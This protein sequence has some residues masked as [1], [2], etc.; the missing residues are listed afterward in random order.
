MYILI[1]N[2][3]QANK[4]VIVLVLNNINISFEHYNCIKREVREFMAFGESKQEGV[5][6][7]TIQSRGLQ[8][9][10]CSEVLYSI[11]KHSYSR[12]LYAY[13][14]CAHIWSVLQLEYMM[15]TQFRRGGLVSWNQ[16]YR[17]LELLCVTRIVL[18]TTAGKA[19]ILEHGTIAKSTFKRKA[20]ISLM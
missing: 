1:K 15:P 6:K 3:L 5:R 20:N 4:W 11:K 8:S 7:S 10:L 12:L 13:E 19:N 18:W 14:C 16:C 17:L 2:V 9:K